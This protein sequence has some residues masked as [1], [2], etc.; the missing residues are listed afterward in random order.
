MLRLIP[1]DLGY[2]LDDLNLIPK[3][4][5]LALKASTVQTFVPYLYLCLF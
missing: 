1:N 2:F 4:R 3:Q 5:N